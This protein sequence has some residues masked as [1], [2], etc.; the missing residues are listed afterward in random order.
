MKSL[1]AKLFFIMIPI[2]NLFA[3]RFDTESK[4]VKQYVVDQLSK[5]IK[6]DEIAVVYN[7]ME[8]IEWLVTNQ[9][10][11]ITYTQSN[12]LGLKIGNIRDVL[13]GDIPPE[14]CQGVF[15][16]PTFY[17]DLTA[18]HEMMGIPYAPMMMEDEMYRLVFIHPQTE[19]LKNRISSVKMPNMPDYDKN[20]LFVNDARVLPADNFMKKYKLEKVF[21]NRV[22]EVTLG[23]MFGV[24]YSLSVPAPVMRHFREQ[25]EQINFSRREVSEIVYIAYLLEGKDGSVKYAE[26]VKRSKILEPIQETTFTTQIGQKLYAKVKPNM[27]AGITAKN[28]IGEKK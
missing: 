10:V 1:L 19:H 11:G 26:A 21:S 23:C 24:D 8:Q 9:T 17:V 16:Y 28:D 7:S 5:A 2:L 15:F 6:K 3:S 20:E 14:N 13:K 4:H 18:T 27:G 22:Y 12:L 25:H